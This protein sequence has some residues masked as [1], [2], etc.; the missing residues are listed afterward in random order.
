MS[1]SAPIV[2]ALSGGVDSATCAGLLVEAGE[3]VVGISMRLYSAG[4]APVEGGRC[5]GPRDLEDARAVCAHLG[6]P[7]YVANY[8]EDFRR[9]VMDDFAA[10]YREGKTPNPCV[11]CNQYIKFTPLLLRARALGARALAT[12]HYARIESDVD[13]NPRLLRGV[14]TGKDQSYFL[15]AMP[16]DALSFVRFPLGGMTKEEVR[17]HAKRLGLPNADKQE[18]QEVCFVPDG[19]YAHFIERYVPAAAGSETAAQGEAAALAGEVVDEQGAVLG[20]HAGIHRYTVGQRRGLGNEVAAAGDGEPRYVIRIDALTRRIH[21][22]RKES[23]LRDEA[24]VSEPH[25]LGPVPAA[26]TEIE[27]GVQIRY[28]RKPQA[29]RLRLREDGQVAVHFAAA[30]HA[31]TPGQA[32][33]FYQGDHVLGGGFLAA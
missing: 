22:G 30:E 7:F 5:C 21:V 15:F 12:G 19:D 32:A 31:I 4:S 10:T 24:L 14:D 16:K 26:G 2:V 13:G 1:E 25:W 6:I 11:R 27:A 28:R 20:E 33:V 29:A 17:A 3:R 8:E 23:L 18:S 9:A